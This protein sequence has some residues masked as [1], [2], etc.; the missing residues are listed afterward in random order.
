MLF[1]GAA[2]RVITPDFPA[3]LCGYP[4]PKDRYHDSVHDELKIHAFYLQNGGEEFL[5]VGM[6]LIYYTKKR[7]KSA[8]ELTERV[9]GIP[10]GHVS[11]TCTHTHSGPCPSSVP[12]WIR[13][14]D[15]E[16]YP[17]YLDFVDSQIA[18]AAAEAKRNAFPAEIGVG[19]GYCGK[20]QGVG[21]NRR[22]KDGICDPSVNVIAIREA[23]GGRV[24]GIIVNYALH[25]TFL[26]AES[27]V[28]TCDYPGYIYEYLRQ[29]D[30]GLVV[31]FFTGASG[32]QSSR[33]FRSGQ[34]FE[35]AKR[36]GYA[37]AAEAER[38]VQGLS[39]QADPHLFARSAE[40]WPTLK[41]IKPLPE[42]QADQ[43]KAQKDL[44]DAIASGMIYGERR[45]L[46]CTLI[47][48]NRMLHYAEVGESAMA[49]FRRNSPYEIFELAIGDAR[50]IT[51]P[52]EIFVEYGLRLKA[53]SPYPMTIFAAYSNGY[54]AGYV[55]T[56]E[57]HAE[58]GYEAVGSMYTGEAGDIVIDE[59]VRLLKAGE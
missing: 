31:G 58:G 39:W 47:G 22:H 43:R 16:M 36:V 18:Q 34:N 1:A 19:K 3:L 59:A 17:H 45:T 4:E 6:D 30:S 8:R 37:I 46:E 52:G 11:I 12:F 32:N 7:V 9:T 49:A 35:E 56:P 2:E 23:D 38:V 29:Q 21:G 44:D 20:E 25:P 10:A 40:A 13:D 27:T 42:A 54:G 50:L 41:V 55:C 33:H 53:E 26:H 15:K 28:L 5:L 51:V 14:D 24:R 57:A 48:A